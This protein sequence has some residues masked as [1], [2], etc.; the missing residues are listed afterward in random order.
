MCIRWR[1]ILNLNRHVMENLNRNFSCVLCIACLYGCGLGKVLKRDS[2]RN[3]H[4]SQVER[5]AEI[6]QNESVYSE[7]ALVFSDSSRQ[8]YKVMIFPRDSFSYS[9]DNGFRGY[10]SRIE[11]S[12]SMD[13]QTS[14]KMF[15]LSAQQRNQRISQSNSETSQSAER[16]VSKDLK[17][18]SFSGTIALILTLAILMVWCFWKFRRTI[19]PGGV[20]RKGTAYRSCLLRK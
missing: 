16:S 9:G 20:H 3:S 19:V 12:G 4:R 6:N 14:G 13:R 17:A 11:I 15:G 5:R 18:K 2:I 10:A 1:D 7:R 8:H